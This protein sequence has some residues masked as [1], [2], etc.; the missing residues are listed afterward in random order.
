MKLTLTYAGRFTTKKDGSPLIGKNGRPYTSLRI[1]ANEYGD[2]YISGFESA[3]TKDWKAGDTVEADVEDTG[4]YLNFNVPKKQAGGMSADDMAY[5]K[6]ELTAIRQEQVM[7][8]QLLQAKGQIPKADAVSVDIPYPE[9]ES[10]MDG[11]PF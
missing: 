1:K 10:E 7:V 4:Q 5:I 6:R 11:A 2:K 3:E 9:N 8:R